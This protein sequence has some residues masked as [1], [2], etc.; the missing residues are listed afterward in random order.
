MPRF[1]QKAEKGGG[2]SQGDGGRA[3]RLRLAADAGKSGYFDGGTTSASF[4]VELPGAIQVSPPDDTDSG[5]EEPGQCSEETKQLQEAVLNSS[6]DEVELLLRAKADPNVKFHFADPNKRIK[7]PTGSSLTAF[8]KFFG[9]A[10]SAAIMRND[11][12]MVETL[13]RGK[14]DLEAT[15]SFRAGLRRA[16]AEQTPIFA[17][18][19]KGSSE[20]ITKLLR[21][22]VRLDYVGKMDD[23]PNNTLLWHACYFGNVKFVRYLL[24]K[25]ANHIDLPAKS[26]DEDEV[27]HTPLH[28]VAKH[29]NTAVAQALLAAGAHVD[30]ANEAGETPLTDAIDHDHPDVV[31]LLVSKAADVLSA[32]SMDKLFNRKNNMVTITAAAEGLRMNCQATEEYVKDNL[33]MD[34][35]VKFLNTPGDAAMHIIHIA[36]MNRHLRYYENKKRKVHTT[37]HIPNHRFNVAVGPDAD[38]LPEWNLGGDDVS[39]VRS[40]DGQAYPFDLLEKAEGFYKELLP[41]NRVDIAKTLPNAAPMQVPIDV[42]QCIVKGIHRNVDVLHAIADT[43]NNHIFN[44]MGC[45][46]VVELGWRRIRRLYIASLAVNLF[47]AVLMFELVSSLNGAQLTAKGKNWGTVRMI[48]LMSCWLFNLAKEVLQLIGYILMGKWAFY[49]RISNAVD[50]CRLTMT[51]ITVWMVFI[52][53]DNLAGFGDNARGPRLLL[54]MVCFFRW[55]KVL[56]ALNGF[57]IFGPSMLPIQTGFMEMWT[58]TAVV[59]FP[60]VGFCHAYYALGIYRDDLIRVVDI[61]YRLGFIGEHDLLE[62]EN[63]EEDAKGNPWRITVRVLLIVVSFFVGLTMMNIFIAVVGE[64]YMVASK[65]KMLIFWRNK[66]AIVL[67]ENAVLA[68]MRCRRICSSANQGAKG[69]TIHQS[70]TAGGLSFDYVWFCCPKEEAMAA[71]DGTIE[72]LDSEAKAP[73]T[74][75]DLEDV[76]NRIRNI[77]NSI[78][79]IANAVAQ[80]GRDAYVKDGRDVVGAGRC[81]GDEPPRAIAGAGRNAFVKDGQNAVGAARRAGGETPQAMAGEGHDAIRDD[82]HD[83]V[84]GAHVAG[85]E[86]LQAMAGAGRSPSVLDVFDAGGAARPAGRDDSVDFGHIPGGAAG[87]SGEWR[88]SLSDQSMVEPGT[89]HHV[90]HILDMV[91]DKKSVP[92]GM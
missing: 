43:A 3:K 13:V 5:L 55:M 58:F 24:P 86:P 22:G 69:L 15:F 72:E 28:I 34:H 30:K 14:A 27:T 37:A 71:G 49:C 56:N 51:G 82:E 50:L 61:I 25:A 53:I 41:G 67:D 44:E 39:C 16:E 20:C 32:A 9:T 91:V 87:R 36:F 29:G 81:A 45:Q 77:E 11:V 40:S 54:A 90:M 35:V 2:S 80:P 63:V 31:R 23:E 65:E 4:S 64:A 74:V 17:A 75:Q 48:L 8:K 10:V 33:V 47:F 68:A 88:R 83:S 85:D 66:A 76:K 26:Q 79:T 18:V 62:M 7:E 84:G 38:S 52:D 1:S 6:S 46:A 21:L 92:P 78:A 60:L 59:M 70:D 42:F 19:A 12:T 89:H 73:A 57:E